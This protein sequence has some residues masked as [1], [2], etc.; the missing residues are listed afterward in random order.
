M[1]PFE[2]VTSAQIDLHWLPV[3]AYIKFKICVLAYQSLNSTAPA[4]ISDILQPVSTLFYLYLYPLG[5]HTLPM[6]ANTEALP[7]T[8]A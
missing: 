2:H 6:H 5:W 7:H 4:Y 8:L 1:Q 3:A